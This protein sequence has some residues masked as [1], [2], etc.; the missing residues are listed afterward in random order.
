MEDAKVG[1]AVRAVRIRRGMR[2]LDVAAS[3]GVTQASVSRLERG[4]LQGM[5]VERIRA[6]GTAVGMLI[7]LTPRWQGGELDRL[8][9]ARHS[10]LHE[11]VARRFAA[12]PEWTI[13]PEV[14]FSVYGERGAI[15]VL[16]WHARTRT[17]LVIELKT[18]V[19]D[20][21]ELLGTLDRKRRL[22]RGIAR[23]RGWDA[24]VV[25]TWVIL[26][27]GRTNRRRVEAHATVLRAALPDDG[28]TVGPWLRAPRGPMAALSIWPDSREAHRMSPVRRVRV[29]RRAAGAVPRA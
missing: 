4:E 28:R 29:P 11:V 10:H 1:R 7:D 6:I 13:L 16:A 3:A 20:V 22:A 12:L 23:D 17:V 19:V 14:T 24:A 5:T 15:D 8:L 21:Q 26:A 27:D 18:E 25:A 9:G 2:Q